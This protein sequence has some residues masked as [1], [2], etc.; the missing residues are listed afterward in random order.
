MMLFGVVFLR[1]I[2]HTSQTR[3][4]IIVQVREYDVVVKYAPPGASFDNVE[5]D[6]TVDRPNL[7]GWGIR[8]FFGLI[9]VSC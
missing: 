1:R 4:D 8:K 7:L 3:N 5:D 2:A 6:D 9:E